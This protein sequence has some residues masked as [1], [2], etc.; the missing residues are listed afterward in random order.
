MPIYFD[1]NAT[2]PLAPEVLDAMLPILRGAHGNPSSVHRYGRIARDR[3]EQARAELAEAVQCEPSELVF[4]S[5]GSEADNMALCGAALMHPDRCIYYGSTE[6]PA[7]LETA[8]AL[9]RQGRKCASVPVNTHGQLDW[10]WLGQTAEQQPPSLLSVMMVNN[11]TGVIQDM[12]PAQ[13][14]VEDHQAL[15]HVDAVQALGKLP[16]NFRDSRADF[17]SLSAH[18][19]HGPR[20]IGALVQRQGVDLPR[21]IHGGGQERGRRGGT[22][23]LAAAVGFGAAAK[24]AVAQLADWQAHCGRLQQRLLNGLRALSGVVVHGLG[25]R[26][27]ANTVQFSTN[28]YEGEALLMALDRE[29]I[30]VSSG[31]ACASGRHEPSHVL[32]AMGCSPELARAAVR[33]SLGRDNTESQV[34]Q[35]LAV[36]DGLL[37]Q[38]ASARHEV[39]A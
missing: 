10:Q 25:S 9:Q 33:V 2:T 24:L 14:F 19:I 5:G 12:Q 7:V 27:V 11:E 8:E 31:S 34:D 32:L 17:M 37:R 35:F 36:L 20:G 16:L 21:L 15:L 1:H 26:R 13:T 38:A 39:V 6:H 22:E 30:A 28:H 23:N 18:K 29:G 4:V 3:L